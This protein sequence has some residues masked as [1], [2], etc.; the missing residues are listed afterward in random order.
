MR[1]AEREPDPQV[2]ATLR[3][4]GLAHQAM[5]RCPHAEARS[6]EPLPAPCVEGLA[7]IKTV[8]G[9]GGLTSCPHAALRERWVHS[10]VQA[11]KWREAGHVCDR[12]GRLTMVLAQAIEAVD[13][14]IAA[15]D[16]DDN[17]RRRK[18]AKRGG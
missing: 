10:A 11:R 18:A 12:Y 16:A 17:E 7:R 5:W 9:A 15:R 2:A 14:G 8:T 4:S 6:R 3:T 13:E 1:K